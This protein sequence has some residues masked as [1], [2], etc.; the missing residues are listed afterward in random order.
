MQNSGASQVLLN[1]LC[2]ISEAQE[3][4]SMNTDRLARLAMRNLNPKDLDIMNL[5]VK[6]SIEDVMAVI[7]NKSRKERQ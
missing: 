7:N 4:L 6:I 3:S 2:E 5:L 1:I